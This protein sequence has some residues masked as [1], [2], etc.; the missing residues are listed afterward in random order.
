[1]SSRRK[2]LEV[3]SASVGSLLIPSFSWGCSPSEK[4]NIGFIG[5][6][7]RAGSNLAG[8][9]SENIVA[10]ADVDNVR[11]KASWEKFPQARRYKDFREM[12]D[13]EPSLDAVVV[14][15][16][17]HMHA[18]ASIA[19]MQRGKHVY[20][21]KPLA[22]TV[23]EARQM[24]A[25][26]QTENVITQMGTQG[27]AFE[28]SRTAVEVIRSGVLGDVTQLHVWSDRPGEWWT[29]GMERPQGDHAVPAGLNWD[30]WLGVA[31]ERPY[32]PAYVPFKWRGF[33]D[34]GTGAIGD[35]GIHNLDTAFWGLGLS[36]PHSARIVDSGAMTSDSPPS[37]SV[38]EITFA[39]TAARPR[40]QLLW[41]DGGKKPPRELFHEVGDEI[42]TNGS[43]V[44]G[45][46]ATLYTR[47]WHGGNNADDMFLL[48]PRKQFADFTPSA[49]S[50]PRP[51]S[52]HQEWIDG[53]KRGE[54]APESSNFAYAAK[55]TETLLLGNIA[56]RMGR[57]VEWDADKMQVRGA[58]EADQFIKPSYRRG[59]ELST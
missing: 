8:C 7:G 36:S 47:T 25:T 4:L 24:A 55:L 3:T 9:S 27:H 5:A 35:M 42:P 13:K 39:E 52:H 17:D 50:L 16:P 59:W 15:T 45:K 19:A 18:S 21:E 32:H 28:G 38:T 46:N 34:F 37:W 41:Y 11:A 22:R 14:S 49:P 6:G 53:I 12:L 10:L 33:W 29:Q 26:A 56:M 40:I 43:L 57:D 30:L 51:G 54:Q 1:M 20:C 58:P 44:V 23:W 31:P 48:L 2:F